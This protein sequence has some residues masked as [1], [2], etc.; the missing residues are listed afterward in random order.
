MA[1]DI[2][3]DSKSIEDPLIWG[4]TLVAVTENHLVAIPEPV[5][6]VFPVVDGSN[7]LHPLVIDRA[8]LVF[9]QEYLGCGAETIIGL[10]RCLVLAAGRF[11]AFTAHQ[12]T[13]KLL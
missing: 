8:S 3:R 4:Q 7:K 12:A 9:V 1:N 13:R 10:V 6:I 5:L 2:D 11:V